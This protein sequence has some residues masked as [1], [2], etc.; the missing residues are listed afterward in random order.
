MFPKIAEEIKETSGIDI[1]LINKGMLKLLTEQKQQEYKRIMAIQNQSGEQAD[2]FTGEELRRK[3]PALSDAIKG[4]MYIEKDGQVEANQ[5]TLGLLKSAAA[6][7]VVIKEY[8]EV[9]DFQLSKGKVEGVVTNQGIF[10]SENVIVAGGAWSQ[11]LL[12]ETGLQLDT[13]PVKG[14][15]FSVVTHRQM[16][17]TTIFSHGCYLVPKKR[18]KNN[19]WCYC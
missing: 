17:S 1:G 7:G 13:Y 5:L 9:Y 2:W 18:W 8:V 4:A 6:S 11:K 14:E 15:C 3:E 16:L 19:C 10:T 12:S